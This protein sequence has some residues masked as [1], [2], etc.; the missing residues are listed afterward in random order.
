MLVIKRLAASVLRILMGA[1]CALTVFVVLL[2]PTDPALAAIPWMDEHE[3][4]ARAFTAVGGT[5]FLD[6]RYGESWFPYGDT[7]PLGQDTWATYGHRIDC[8]GLLLKAWEVP[9][10]L[11]YPE[12]NP[13]FGFD[14]YTASRFYNEN[15]EW[16]AVGSPQRGDAYT[17][18]GHVFVYEKEGDAGQQWR[19]E[20]SSTQGMTMHWQKP[21][22]G[23]GWRIKRRTYLNTVT[24]EIHLDNPSAAYFYSA[25]ANPFRDSPVSGVGEQNPYWWGKSTSVL[26]YM[27]R[28]YVF[29]WPDSSY[30]IVAKWTPE[31][32]GDSY[33]AIYVK[34]TPHSNRAT[35]VR[36][37][38]KY[39]DGT[40]SKTRDQTQ[41]PNNA[42]YPGWSSLT[43]D[44][45]GN[46]VPIPIVAGW[47]PNNT[48]NSA[49]YVNAVVSNPE[50]GYTANGHVVADEVRYIWRAPRDW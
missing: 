29:H 45:N 47:S 38:I 34:W 48:D 35:N 14:R 16:F 3:I 25:R 39:K 33:Y 15:V 7:P 46:E 32:R 50:I 40:Y 18:S 23:S 1:L 9:Q 43:C 8:S 4:I 30:K 5:Y 13:P 42:N 19:F 12:E 24:G 17:S 27:G 41:P 11:Y 31:V 21:N 2:L 37:E 36:Y 44:S 49:S 10:T 26:G 20:A 28:D 22:P 6:P